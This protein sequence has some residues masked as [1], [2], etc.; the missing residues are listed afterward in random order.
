MGF[1]E[2]TGPDYTE[3]LLKRLQGKVPELT[4]LKQFRNILQPELRRGVT[5]LDIDFLEDLEFVRELVKRLPETN[6]SFWT[7]LDIIKAL[8]KEPELLK[9]RRPR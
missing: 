7:T 2:I 1:I 6:A 5:M 9:I 8:D 4:W 3:L